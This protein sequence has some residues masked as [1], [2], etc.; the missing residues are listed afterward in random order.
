MKLFVDIGNSRLKWMCSEQERA[1]SLAWTIRTLPE[2]LMSAWKDIPAPESIYISNV[3]GGEAARIVEQYSRT[4][5]DREPQFMVVSGRCRDLV[6]A[7]DDIHQMGVDRWM[8]LIAAWS[9]YKDNLCIIDFGT[10]ITVDLVLADGRHLGGYILPGAG[11][12]RELL[13]RRA[14]GIKTVFDDSSAITPG[15]STS[16]CLGNGAR[17]AVTAL[18]EK[19]ARES[20]KEHGCEFRCIITGGDAAVF[21]KTLTVACEYDPDLVLK[22]MAIVSGDAG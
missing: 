1:F 20:G 11:L 8:A 12:M 14:H 21:R 5:W 13:N 16:E 2:K 18:I 4:N 15:T 3:A 6:N 9:R 10:A 7:Y 22:G 17:L 19:V